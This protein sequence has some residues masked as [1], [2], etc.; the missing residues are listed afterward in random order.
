MTHKTIVTTLSLALLLLALATGPVLA[1]E[2]EALTIRLNRDFGYASL[3]GDDIQGRF[4]LEAEGPADLERVAFLLDGVVVA[5]DDEAPFEWP[6]QTGNYVLG[7]HTISATG[8]A[9]GGEVL[10]SRVLNREFVEPSS[11]PTAA[12]KAVGPIL[13]VLAVVTILSYLVTMVADRRKAPLPLGARRDY[14]MRGGAICPRC[15]RPFALHFFKL[16]LLTHSLDRCPHCGR[17]GLVRRAN[18]AALA[19]AEA[20][21]L[22]MARPAEGDA[23]AGVSEEERRRKMLDDSRFD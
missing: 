22:E 4:T 9:A 17:W 1:Q 7:P 5:E 16:N 21:E 18:P 23:V 12:L 13:A 11:G 20:A 19:A 3:G 2:E 10:Q 15:Q 8:Y 14:G 6:F